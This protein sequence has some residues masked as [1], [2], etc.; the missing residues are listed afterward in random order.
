MDRADSD[1]AGR[2]IGRYLVRNKIGAGGMGEVYRAWDSQL[3]RDI[4]LKVLPARAFADPTARSR[5]IREARI[6]SKLNHPGICTMYDTGEIDG[7]AYIAMELLEGQVLGNI[8]AAGALT[9]G[10]VMR[11]GTQLAD[12]LAHAHERG[13]LHRDFKSGNVIVT[14]DDRVKILDFGLAKH[15][16]DAEVSRA[17][18]RIH[19]TVVTPGAISG[20]LS[21]LAPEQLRGLSADERSDLWALGVV[22]Y[23]MATGQ[24]P[25]AGNTSFEITAAIL[26]HAPAPMPPSVPGHIASIID[27]CLRKD[28]D[29]RCQSAAQV[30][31]ALQTIASPRAAATPRQPAPGRRN[32]VVVA[33]VAA[34]L[35]VA[36]ALV[37]LPRDTGGIFGT[38]LNAF[39]ARDWLLVANFENHTNDRV[40]DQS[41]DTAMAV[42]IGQSSYVNVVPASRIAGAMRRMR[43]K[44]QNRIDGATARQIAERES[45]KLVLVPTITEVGGV[46]QLSGTLE[47]P[48]TGAVL[49]S[50]MVRA[51]RKEEVL[52]AADELIAQIRNDL[53]EARRSISQQSKPLEQV[54]TDSLEALKVFS[55]AREAYTNA[56]IDEAVTLY[57]DA[58]RLDPSFTGAKAQLGM[59]QFELRDREKGKALLA[60]AI[61]DVDSLTYKERYG[62]LAFHALAVENNPQKAIDHYTALLTLYPDLGSAYNNIGRADMQM[63]R[64]DLAVVNLRK[65][66]QI[67]PDVM[68]TYNSLNQIY[69]YQLGDLDAAIALCRQ[70]ILYN[71]Q[72]EYAYD[73][74][75]WAMLGKSDLNQ[76]R[77]A[78]QKALAINPRATFDIFRLGHTYRL[79]GRYR[80][81]RDTFLTIPAIDPR[82]RSAYYDAGVAS[83]LMGDAPGARTLFLKNRELVEQAIHD[84]AKNAALYF[85]LAAV[86]ARLGR[87]AESS[88]AADRGVAL[89]PNLHFE[90]ATV[91]AVQGRTADAVRQ[92]QQAVD[93]GYSDFVWIK[94]HEDFD[95]LAAEPAFQKVLAEKLKS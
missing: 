6:A 13:V 11:Y 2:T 83:Q 78:F 75:G 65:A 66:L 76:A 49:K 5:L 85:E 62:V 25:F 37:Y 16:P 61:A 67:D 74:L 54:T 91:L 48:A 84:D 21:Y 88:A 30:R 23:E 55:Q 4:A 50:A 9:A 14:P 73:N 20:T 92:V 95:G 47:N 64:W 19:D 80:E 90:Y 79:E 58:L 32:V 45:V 89:D 22:L 34:L 8:L 86:Q 94:I 39:S 68:L 31:T 26:E 35:T 69:L 71:D 10:R 43:I 40:F 46:Y 60:D 12:A 17:T 57:E 28:P 77:D 3:E 36:A 33:G 51:N 44:V 59:I 42:G 63:K 29:E 72:T 82:E 1:L 15:L 53:G 38:S 93:G 7:Q 87:R 27:Q 70:Q 41:L 81:A 18:T 56:R 52:K 24:P